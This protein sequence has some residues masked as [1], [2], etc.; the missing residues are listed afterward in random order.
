M[1]SNI[2]LSRSLIICRPQHWG[3][4]RTSAARPAS[5]VRNRAAS[6][7]SSH[8]TAS[9]Q[10]TRPT[11]SSFSQPNRCSSLSSLTTQTPA[12]VSTEISFA[13][14]FIHSRMTRNAEDAV[15]EGQ[16][17]QSRNGQAAIQPYQT[18]RILQRF[19]EVST[20]AYSAGSG[21]TPNSGNQ[22][23]K[24]KATKKLKA[25]P[26]MK[27][28][29]A[30]RSAIDGDKV[31][32]QSGMY[33]FSQ[34]A[35]RRFDLSDPRNRASSY[36]D[37]TIVGDPV[38]WVENERVTV[39]GFIHVIERLSKRSTNDDDIRDLGLTRS[40]CFAWL[41]FTY[42]TARE[43]K[44]HKG[45]LLRIYNA[46]CVPARTSIVLDGLVTEHAVKDRCC[47]QLI[48]STEL[49]ESYPDCLPALPSVLGKI[50]ADN[51]HTNTELG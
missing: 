51:E 47:D 22:R 30:I 11:S 1:C 39:L 46:I 45:S 13:P 25:G 36:M 49:C 14:P 23:W 41:C 48:L 20:A 16:A 6:P 50:T 43:Q 21:N 38:P 19:N 42:E 10:K 15:E 27:R 24:R 26:L 44:L 32:F 12:K 7:R 8:F 29:R 28:L 33:P 4:S 5:W 40:S 2:Q 18:P 37:V 34:S 9:L 31:R 35:N 17:S 3:A